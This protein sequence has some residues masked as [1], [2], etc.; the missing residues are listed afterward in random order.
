MV[1]A[2]RTRDRSLATLTPTSCQCKPTKRS[3]ARLSHGGQLQADLR[4]ESHVGV[5]SDGGKELVA[6]TDG[7][8]ESTESWADLLPCERGQASLDCRPGRS[9][10]VRR[11]VRFPSRRPSLMSVERWWNSAD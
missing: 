5:R 11:R 10:R 4:P 1:Q 3:G 6:L 7:Y 9:Y 8:R 2:G